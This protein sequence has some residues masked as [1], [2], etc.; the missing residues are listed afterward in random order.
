MTGPNACFSTESDID[1][2]YHSVNAMAYNSNILFN[3]HANSNTLVVN[4][5]WIANTSND[6]GKYNLE[7]IANQNRPGASVPWAQLV[8]MLP[9]S[10]VF[11]SITTNSKLTNY[12]TCI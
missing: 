2:Y 8:E 3:L 7:Y 5:N 11:A 9:G 1:V 10:T 6:I 4:K 12:N